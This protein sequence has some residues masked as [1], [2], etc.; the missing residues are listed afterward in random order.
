MNE[1]E[2]TVQVHAVPLAAPPQGPVNSPS[3]SGSPKGTVEL[4]AHGCDFT[5]QATRTERVGPLL[6]ERPRGRS[7]T[8]CSLPGV[9]IKCVLWVELFPKAEY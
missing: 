5:R 4:G 6:R 8:V 7:A 3:V 2:E 9:K 1:W